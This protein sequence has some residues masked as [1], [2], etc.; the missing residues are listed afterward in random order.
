MS[1]KAIRYHVT[2]LNGVATTFAYDLWLQQPIGYGDI[3]VKLS[4]GQKI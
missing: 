1:Q 4:P 3:E 2:L